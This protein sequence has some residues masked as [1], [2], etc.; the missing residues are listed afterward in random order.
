MLVRGEEGAGESKF[1]PGRTSGRGRGQDLLALGREVGFRAEDESDRVTL[2]DEADRRRVVVMDAVAGGYAGIGG[3]FGLWIGPEDNLA[4]GYPLVGQGWQ[5]DNHGVRL[6]G[7]HPDP[8]VVKAGV[9]EGQV[10]VNR[11]AECN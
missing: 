11:Q 4:A 8:R 3:R 6:D 9:T 7:R 1:A 2:S 10:R 5:A